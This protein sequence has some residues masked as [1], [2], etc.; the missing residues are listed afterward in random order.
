M[1]TSQPKKTWS[2]QDNKRTQAE[3]DLF[4]ATG[5][6]KKN[7][8]VTYLLSVI[9]ALLL[10]SFILPKLYDEVITICITDTICLN[11]EHNYIL[12]PLYIFCTI[13]VLILAIYGAYVVGKKIG[14]KFKV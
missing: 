7:K 11:S 9:G 1:E 13:V 2:L 14:E 4:K 5:K 3:R 12:Y 10:V 8:N 6:P